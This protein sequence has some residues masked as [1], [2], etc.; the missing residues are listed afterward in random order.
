[1]TYIED[2][3]FSDD[4]IMGA[5]NWRGFYGETKFDEGEWGAGSD[6]PALFLPQK[7]GECAF[8]RARQP[9]EV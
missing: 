5:I 9:G 3:P 4:E 8:N 7:G 1:M 2:R 6:G